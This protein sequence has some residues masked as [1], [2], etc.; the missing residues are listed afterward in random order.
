MTP[1]I[2]AALIGCNVSLLI[3]LAI[4]IAMLVARV[5]KMEARQP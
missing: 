3:P 1:L 4:V 2:L 5:R